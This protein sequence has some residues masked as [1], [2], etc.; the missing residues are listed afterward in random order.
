MLLLAVLAMLTLTWWATSAWRAQSAPELTP[1]AQPRHVQAEPAVPARAAPIPPQAVAPALAARTAASSASATAVASPRTIAPPGKGQDVFDFCGRAP[2]T[3]DEAMRRLPEL[4]RD[5]LRHR[6]EGR[7]AR[8]RL[9]AA[10]LVGSEREQVVAALISGLDAVNAGKDLDTTPCPQPDVGSKCWSERFAR[11]YSV[12]QPLRDRTVK[13]T[14]NSRDP[15]VY[16]VTARDLCSSLAAGAAPAESSC[17]LLT[18]ELWRTRSPDDAAPSL[19]QAELALMRKEPAAVRDAMEQAARAGTLTS[20]VGLSLG[21][22]MTHPAFTAMKPWHRNEL[23]SELFALGSMPSLRSVVDHCT[24]DPMPAGVQRETCDKLV[25]L[26]L[27]P[28][29]SL[30]GHFVGTTLAKRLGWPADQVALLEERKLALQRQHRAALL[31]PDFMSCTGMAQR[32]QYFAEVAAQ[33]EAAALDARIKASGRTVAQLAAEARAE[34]A[35]VAATRAASA[36][37]R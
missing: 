16:A 34:Q 37:S 9:A 8:K 3:M 25:R 10:L 32:Q 33:G 35:A 24:G 29:G 1:T 21:P 7:A 15:W 36:A 13:L 2:I 12:L 30:V 18:P 19:W 28:G 5:E 17:A 4:E 14:L 26:A 31:P 22:L 23:A 20:T 6:D 11:Q 27:Q